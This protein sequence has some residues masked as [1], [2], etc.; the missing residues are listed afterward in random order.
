[1]EVSASRL[2]AA[3][4]KIEELLAL[5]REGKV[6]VPRFQRPLRWTGKDVERLFDSIYKGYPVGT[7]L[8]WV[9]EAE[10]E[11]VRLG[12]VTIDAPA[13]QEANWVVDGQQRLTSLVGSFAPE[14]CRHR[15][16]TV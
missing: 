12:P 14:R 8:F 9:R 5:V 2:D 13:Q 7:L 10:A 1:M 11:H 16:P 3:R 4:Y 6:R 15:G